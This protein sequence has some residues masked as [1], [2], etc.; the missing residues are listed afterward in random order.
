MVCIYFLH[1]AINCID[2]LSVKLFF[3]SCYTIET[4]FFSCSG[5]NLTANTY[6]TYTGTFYFSF[7]RV[8]FCSKPILFMY[9]YSS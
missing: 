4:I 2:I 8:N 5:I 9:N 6:L 1:L 3:A 7:C